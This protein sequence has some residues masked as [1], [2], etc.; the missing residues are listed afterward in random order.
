M[1][2][3]PLM[4]RLPVLGL[5][6]VAC[7]TLSACGGATVAAPESV[8]VSPAPLV[9]TTPIPAVVVAHTPVQVA[10][11]QAAQLEAAEEQYATCFVYAALDQGL[12][13]NTG[14]ADAPV[15]QSCSPGGL[16]W[17]EVH[18]IQGLIMQAS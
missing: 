18:E 16:T 8:P 13:L 4:R 17:A 11:V 6:I 15:V 1:C 5:S 7:L 12:A 14:R 3:F 9:S 2:R 10:Q